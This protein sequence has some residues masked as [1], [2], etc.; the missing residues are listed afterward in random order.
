MI[1][2]KKILP[3]GQRENAELNL[4][5]DIEI[6]ISISSHKLKWQSISIKWFTVAFY[7]HQRVNRGLKPRTLVTIVSTGEEGRMEGPFAVV[8]STYSHWRR[9]LMYVFFLC[10]GDMSLCFCNNSVFKCRSTGG[11]SGLIPIRSV[12]V[13]RFFALS[14]HSLRRLKS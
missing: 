14:S 8:N 12:C 3:S 5:Y 10:S 7:N 9:Y 13:R 1:T 6:R 11:R 2:A 4:V